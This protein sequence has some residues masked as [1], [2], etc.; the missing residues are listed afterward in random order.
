MR[1]RTDHFFPPSLLPS[2][3]QLHSSASSL[4]RMWFLFRPA[5]S[6]DSS[7]ELLLQERTALL[8]VC[9]MCVRSLPES[10]LYG[11]CFPE[12]QF[13]VGACFCRSFIATCRASCVSC[14][15]DICSATILWATG[16]QPAPPWSG[17]SA[18]VLGAALALLL[19]GCR[20]VSPIFPTC[21][22]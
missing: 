15:L 20:A 9:P 3:A 5:A 2:Q 14:G 17:Q 21:L 6:E 8:W 13:L 22:S 12:P 16:G 1:T 18:L 11:G 10:L 7:I 4:P 19:A